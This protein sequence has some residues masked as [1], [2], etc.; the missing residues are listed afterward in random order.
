MIA[1]ISICFLMNCKEKQVYKN[2]TH[3]K[4]K[5]SSCELILYPQDTIA[6]A[7]DICKTVCELLFPIYLFLFILHV[8]P[9]LRELCEIDI[10]FP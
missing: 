3:I 5:L 2:K 9:L 4:Y 8:F 10:L 1:L 7:L 6:H